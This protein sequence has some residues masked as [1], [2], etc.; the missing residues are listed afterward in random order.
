[1][2]AAL[3][4]AGVP[5][6]LQEYPTGGHGFGYQHKPPDKAPP[7]WLDKAYDWLK[8]QGFMP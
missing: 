4:K 8:G 5:C 7:G 2:L 6:A 1:M 3:Q